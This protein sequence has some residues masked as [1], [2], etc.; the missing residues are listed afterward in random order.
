MSP[1]PP[2]WPTSFS[3]CF[4]F[5]CRLLWPQY[6]RRGTF[7]VSRK[8]IFS[9]A[10]LFLPRDMSV[11]LL[12]LPP[13]LP[14][15]SHIAFK[16]SPPHHPFQSGPALNCYSNI[17]AV[18]HPSFLLLQLPGLRHPL[19]VLGHCLLPSPSPPSPAQPSPP[20][21]NS[22]LVSLKQVLCTS[23]LLVLGKLGYG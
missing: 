19:L 14:Q 1:S 20:P 3:G 6:I 10:F 4:F 2:T 16:S 21:L 8:G 17:A 7:F 13:A 11:R 5:W 18:V 22:Q 9:N 12:D 15:T 23:Q